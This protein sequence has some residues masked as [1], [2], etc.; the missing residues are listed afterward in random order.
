MWRVLVF[1][2]T[3]V[4]FAA[5]VVVGAQASYALAQECADQMARANRFAHM[6]FFDKRGRCELPGRCARGSRAENIGWGAKDDEDQR[7]RWH[8]SKKGH[9]AIMQMGP[10]Y[11]ATATSARG[12]VYR[13]GV[14]G[15]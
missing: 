3:V 13:C 4:A 8:R 12:R 15:G 9:A 1:I 5:I 2:L 10:I 6:G 11:I 7:A 14:V